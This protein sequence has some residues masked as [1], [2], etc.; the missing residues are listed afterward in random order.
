MVCVILIDCHLVEVFLS[1]L[2]HG[3]TQTNVHKTRVEMVSVIVI[4]QLKLRGRKRDEDSGDEDLRVRR[5]KCRRLES[6][7]QDW[8]AEWRVECVLVQT[9]WVVTLFSFLFL[10][11]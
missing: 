1:Q 2:L 6:S 4:N 9:P 5:R 3:Q 11:L 8:A 10:L 7:S